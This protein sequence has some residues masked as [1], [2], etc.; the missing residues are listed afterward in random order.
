MGSKSSKADVA[1]TNHLLEAAL[2]KYFATK[3]FDVDGQTMKVTDI[4][5]ALQKEDV[6]TAS[7]VKARGAWLAAAKT[8]QAET[9]ANDKVRQAVRQAV[10]AALGANSE[11]LGEFGIT[12]KQRVPRTGPERVAAAKKAAATRRAR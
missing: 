9:K 10:K 1:A 5:A 3:S 11:A 4:V 12:V 7:A 8:A 2:V 6:L